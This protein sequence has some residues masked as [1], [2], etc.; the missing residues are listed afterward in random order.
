MAKLMKIEIQ[1]QRTAYYDTVVEVA[2]DVGARE[3]EDFVATAFAEHVELFD[4]SYVEPTGDNTYGV[5]PV[6]D[7]K[8]ERRFLPNEER[9]HTLSNLFRHWREH[10][11]CLP[12]RER[13][14]T[15]DPDNATGYIGD[16]ADGVHYRVVE[17]EGDWWC[18]GLIDSTRPPHCDYLFVDAGPFNHEHQAVDHAQIEACRWCEERGIPLVPDGDGTCSG[19]DATPGDPHVC[20]N[21]VCVFCRQR[22]GKERP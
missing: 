10:G 19:C 17:V 14:V 20:E 8:L 15:V 1:Q 21:G 6:V 3:L 13:L 22:D 4:E 7:V 12:G 2:D 5:L 9:S 16:G 18:S 11:G